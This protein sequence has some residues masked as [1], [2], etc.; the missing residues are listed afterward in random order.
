MSDLNE[1]VTDEGIETSDESTPESS[2]PPA[3]PAPP[4]KGSAE[5][6][7]QMAAKSGM[8]PA[9][10][11]NE[12]GT[13]NVEA[14]AQSYRALETKMSKGASANDD[15]PEDKPAPDSSVNG[16]ETVDGLFDSVEPAPKEDLWEKSQKELQTTGK[17]SDETKAALKKSHNVNDAV[18]N[19]FVAGFQ[20]QQTLTTARLAQAVGGREALE[21]AI[22][23]AKANMPEEALSNFRE[24]LK[25]PNAELVL[26]GVKARMGAQAT[27]APKKGAIEGATGVKNQPA[28]K[29]F[30]SSMEMTKAIRDPRY[31]ADPEFRASVEARIRASHRR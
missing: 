20:A 9:K 30:A 4:V 11:K 24:A 29:P 18:I 2:T 15:K 13:V 28:V 22:K 6:Q 7:A 5:W 12:D 17:L 31:K 23:W 21:S 16:D 26:A 27:P 25:G 14:L 19:S 1:A 8:V 10:F 3:Q